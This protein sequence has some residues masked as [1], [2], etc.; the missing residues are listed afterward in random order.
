MTVVKR[1]SIIG[2]KCAT[3]GCG[4]VHDVLE[5]ATLKDRAPLQT[6]LYSTFQISSAELQPEV[7]IH[8]EPGSGLPVKAVK[9]TL[10]DGCGVIYH[11]QCNDETK[12]QADNLL[13]E[14]QAVEQFRR[15][16]IANTPL[17]TTM[18]GQQFVMNSGMP[19]HYLS[20]AATVSLDESP[21]CVSKAL[22]L[23][24]AKA[25][26]VDHASLSTMP[27]NEALSICY[28]DGQKMNYHSDNERGL[29]GVI[30]SLSLGHSASMDF[31]TYSTRSHGKRELRIELCHVG[32]VPP[33][34]MYGRVTSTP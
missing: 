9:Y 22:K 6:S 30:A 32:E 3:E 5:E 17:S 20:E 16:K 34:E 24:N 14:F 7:K 11:L 15:Q 2:W 27:F 26:L 8:F 29:G 33:S 18:L 25:S 4:G 31:R 23:I 28:F 13:E 1:E 19:Y 10:P 12:K 21:P